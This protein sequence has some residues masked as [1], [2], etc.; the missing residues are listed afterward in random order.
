MYSKKHKDKKGENRLD[1][2]RLRPRELALVAAG[3]GGLA[4]EPDVT[5]DYYD[6]ICVMDN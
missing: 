4:S 6:K 3:V 5:Y 2:G 1:N